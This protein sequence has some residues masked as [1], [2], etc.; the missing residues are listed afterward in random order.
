MT[1]HKAICFFCGKKSDNAIEDGFQP[2][3]ITPSGCHRFQSCN[4]CSHKYLLI[5]PGGDRYLR[6]ERIIRN[7]H[8]T[9]EEVAKYKRIREQVE[10]EL[11]DL[12]RQHHE[13]MS[14]REE[15]MQPGLWTNA[16]RAMLSQWLDD[17]VADIMAH[18]KR[19]IPRIGELD[20]RPK[21]TYNPSDPNDSPS[22]Y[23]MRYLGQGLLEA[24]IARLQEQV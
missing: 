3:F 19:Q 24:L 21:G 1:D 15:T 7:R 6:L 14:R 12:I 20:T 17:E 4:E 16:Q 22:D 13:R 11:P 23:K 18:I 5:D 9:P 8:L 10:Q 2:D